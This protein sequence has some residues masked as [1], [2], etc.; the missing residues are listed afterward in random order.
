MKKQLLVLVLA[1]SLLMT[2]CGGQSTSAEADAQTTGDEA[3]AVVAEETETTEAETEETQEEPEIAVAPEEKVRDYVKG[4]SDENG[5]ASEW[6][7][8]RFT[9][10]EDATMMTEEE[11]NDLMGI[12][13]DL[14]SGDA[15]A[16]QAEYAELTSVIEM[17]CTAESG[18]PNISMSTEKITV[19]VSI[20]DYLKAF[21]E[22]LTS[23]TT[24]T[25]TVISNDE[26]VT[27]GGKEFNKIGVKAE[28]D[29]QTMYQDCYIAMQ[30]DRII[31]NAV[32]YTEDTA[33]QA[34]TMLE[35]FAEY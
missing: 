25:Y 7:G 8:L 14:L 9:A 10:P 34:A 20:E 12:S 5:Y 33:E 15:N 23:V 28:C 27:I 4:T 31:S 19:S 17:I 32:T 1:S 24:M 26:T 22:T 35:G 6:L 3:V 29:G 30:G 2:A 11:L 21:E 18:T 13:K 16:L